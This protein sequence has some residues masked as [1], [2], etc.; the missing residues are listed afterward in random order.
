MTT[1]E[2]PGTLKSF[3]PGANR[4]NSEL[5]RRG[6]DLGVGGRARGKVASSAGHVLSMRSAG[7]SAGLP[8]RAP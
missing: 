6:K 4:H 5:E 1:D 7:K 3:Q 8:R 2:M